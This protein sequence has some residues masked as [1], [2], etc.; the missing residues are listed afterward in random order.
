MLAIERPSR[1]PVLAL[2][3]DMAYLESGPGPDITSGLRLWHAVLKRPSSVRDVADL[4]EIT[5]KNRT[6]VQ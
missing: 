2:V 1:L 5:D 4:S 6:R 3:G